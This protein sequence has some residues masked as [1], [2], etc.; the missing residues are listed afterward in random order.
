MADLPASTAPDSTDGFVPLGERSW[1]R[2]RARDRHVRLD[3]REPAFY[4]NPYPAYE[5]IRAVA[6]Q[7]FWEEQATW[8]FL[9]AADVGTLLRDR[10]FGREIPGQPTGPVPEVSE[11]IATFLHVNRN[12]MLEREPPVHT[13]LRTLVNRAFVSRA[14]ERLRP[15]IAAHAHALIDAVQADGHAELLAAFA[16]PIPVVVIAELLGIPV[17]RADDLLD[18]SHRMVAM[19]QLGRTR[20]ME[21]AAEAATQEFV[22]FMREHVARRRTQPADDLITALIAAEASGDKLSEDELIGTCILLLNAGHEA[23]VHALGNAVKV[24]LEA[25][26]DP[27]RVFANSAATELAVEE[28]LRFDPPLHLFSRIA[29]ADCE[30]AGVLLRAGDSVGLM[31]GAANRDPSRYSEADQFDPSRPASPSH[32]SFGGGIHFCLGAPLARLELQTALPILFQRLPKLRLAE[33]PHYRNAYHFH[34]LESLRVRW[35]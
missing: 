6:P 11:H 4:E 28:T 13:R 21:V 29:S 3:P 23:T 22:A 14:I 15:Q 33:T 19:F 7:F 32:A 18:W 1:L 31:Y 30:V 24:L 10:R 17:D 27:G 26:S 35:D 2:F 16:S 5:A 9:E 12:S 8:C 25:G 34:G 20:Q